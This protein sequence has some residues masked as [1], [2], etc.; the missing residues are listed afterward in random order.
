MLRKRT[1]IGLV[2]SIQVTGVA[3]CTG[4]V[5]KPPKIP[6]AVVWVDMRQ[7][8]RMRRMKWINSIRMVSETWPM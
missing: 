7:K 6:R 5:V 4:V 3:K 2:G 1:T 8:T